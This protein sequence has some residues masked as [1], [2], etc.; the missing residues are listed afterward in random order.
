MKLNSSLTREGL[1]E[2]GRKIS[3]G[4][5]RNIHYSDLMPLLKPGEVIVG[6]YD[7]LIVKD[8]YVIDC[9]EDLE[10]LEMRYRRKVYLYRNLF[11]VSKDKLDASLVQK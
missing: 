11:I 7:G 9:V 5:G 3:L 1:E 4:N 8:I 10:E 6:F 2:I